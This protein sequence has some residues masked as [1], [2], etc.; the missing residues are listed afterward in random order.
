MIEPDDELRSWSEAW[1]GGA[2]TR[3]LDPAAILRQVR[4]QTRLLALVSSL[5]LAMLGAML[6]ALAAFGLSSPD[7]WDWAMVVAFSLLIGAA[8]AR[9]VVVVRR[10]WAAN[11]ET[12]RALVELMILRATTRLVQVRFGWA[13]LPFE[14]AVFVPWIAHRTGGQ[15][16]AVTLGAFGFLL[17]LVVAGIVVLVVL[18]RRGHRELDHWRSLENEV[19]AEGR[20]T[21]GAQ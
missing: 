21:V 2:P 1:K 6:V 5:E 14:V 12:T 4:R 8:V 17:A 15:S 18:R 13:I 11:A 16:A 3:A 9:R 7:P 19:V 10:T 20:R